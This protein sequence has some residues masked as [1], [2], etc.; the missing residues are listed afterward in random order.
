GSL[1]RAPLRGRADVRAFRFPDLYRPQEPGL[2]EPEVCERALG[3]VRSAI[4]DLAAQGARLAGRPLGSIFANEGL[5]WTPAGF[6]EQAAAIVRAA[7]GV[8]NLDEVQG[9]RCRT[10]PL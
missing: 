6:M 2:S 7:G 8:V 4:D 5:P 9:E 3:E 10:G 1:T